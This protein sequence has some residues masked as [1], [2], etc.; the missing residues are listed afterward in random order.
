MP[1]SGRIRGVPYDSMM[2]LMTWLVPAVGPERDN[3][4]ATMDRLAAQHD[5]ARFQPH[6]TLVPNVE[7]GEKASAEALRSLAA[8]MTSIDL[9]FASLGHEETYFRALYLVPEPV[10]QLVALHQA[11][12]RLWSLD[13]WQFRPHLS[14][15]YSEL[16]EERK[17]PMIDSIGIGLPL[18]IRFNAIELWAATPQVRDWYRVAKIPFTE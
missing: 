2:S 3:L 17:R 18:T 14:L 6:V 7:S 5:A 10:E 13:P 9:N 12:Q 15:L 11:V 1:M 4:V 16:S 8:A